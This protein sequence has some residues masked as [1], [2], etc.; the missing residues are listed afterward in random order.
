MVDHNKK[1]PKSPLGDEIEPKYGYVH[2]EWDACGGHHFSYRH[3]DEKTYQESITPEGSYHISHEDDKKKSIRTEL[4]VGEHRDYVCGGRSCQIDG[5]FDHNGEKTGK[6]DHHA[7]FGQATKLNYYRG[8]GKKEF[9][10]AGDSVYHGVQE[11]SSPVHCAARAGTDRLRVK[12]DKFRA[13]EGDCVTMGEKKKIEVFKKDVSM[14]SGANHDTYIKQ[15]GKIETGSTMMIQ[16]GSDA[17]VNSAA[18]IVGKAK[19]DITIESDSKIELKVGGSS[20]TIESGKIT[21]KS[22][23]IDFQQG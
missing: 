3:P 12:G 7:D 20:I 9:K 19:S 6:M 23:Q 2:G 5:H 17:T 21:I 8:T 15:K 11:G 1:A 4:N 10:M 16:T 14:Y 18:K 13:V 22:S